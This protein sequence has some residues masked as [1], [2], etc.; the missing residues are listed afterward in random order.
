MKRVMINDRI[1]IET[2]HLTYWQ[3]I[4]YSSGHSLSMYLLHIFRSFVYTQY[5]PIAFNVQTHRYQRNDSLYL[6][7]WHRYQSQHPSLLFEDVLWNQLVSLDSFRHL[8]LLERGWFDYWYVYDGHLMIYTQIVFLFSRNEWLRMES[9][10]LHQA[11]ESIQ[12]NGVAIWGVSSESIVT[13]MSS[14]RSP[15]SSDTCVSYSCCV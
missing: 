11:V 8:F 5:C 1:W 15:P 10:Q 12:N 7:C 9:E 4:V 6:H 2:K 13:V 3:P 14:R